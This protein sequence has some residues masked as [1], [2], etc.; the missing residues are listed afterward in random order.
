M[1]RLAAFCKVRSL[2]VDFEKVF[3][4]SHSNTAKLC[5]MMMIDFWFH[6]GGQGRKSSFAQ[7]EHLSVKYYLA[8]KNN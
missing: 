2:E 3:G 7:V 6:N 1:S 5:L 8:T 4:N